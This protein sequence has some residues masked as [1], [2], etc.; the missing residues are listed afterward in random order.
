MLHPHEVKERI[1]RY[2]RILNEERK[3]KGSKGSP[4]YNHFNV[5]KP[6]ALR[7]TASHKFCRNLSYII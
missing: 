5:S 4:G 1:E 7:S 2:F 3:K 6:M